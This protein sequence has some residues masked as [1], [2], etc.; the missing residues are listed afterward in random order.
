MIYEINRD[1]ELKLYDYFT[2]LR[3]SVPYYFNT[4]FEHWRES[5]F[6]DCDYDGK[7]L[8]SHL[9]TYLLIDKD[10]IIGFIQYGLTNFT[11]D[12]NG[13]K[14]YTKQYAIIR[15]IHFIENTVNSRLLLDKATAYFNDL[16]VDKRYAFFHY[17][18]MSCYAKQGKL[19]DSEFYIEKLLCEYGY[20]K[21]HENV[22]YTKFLQAADT[23]DV[24]EIDFVCENNGASISFMQS[25]EKIGGC[26]LNFVPYSDICFLKWIYID[27]KYSHQGLGTKCM[28]KLF[29]ELKNRNISRLDTDTADNNINAQGY[30]IKTGFSDM[31]RMRSYFTV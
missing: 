15:N 6:H 3:E 20:V 31:G 7:P 9:E 4:S 25:G 18:G 17:F 26:E 22:Y 1:N 21:E 19:H 14:D 10:E 5:M 29:Y 12:G 13:E 30:Y 28:N 8:F 11:F 2:S 23:Y 24:S 27:E 16:D